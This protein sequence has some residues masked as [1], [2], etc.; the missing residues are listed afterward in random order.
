MIVSLSFTFQ[1]KVIILLLFQVVCA[2]VCCFIFCM[3][4]GSSIVPC[5][6]PW[7]LYVVISFATYEC[8]LFLL[9]SLVYVCIGHHT[10]A[11]H[12][13]LRD[14]PCTRAPVVF[15]FAS[16][17]FTPSTHAHTYTQTVSR[18]HL[19]FPLMPSIHTYIPTCL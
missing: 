13:S 7:I 1:Q 12:F 3:R 16:P 18:T 9:P 17:L 19:L 8:Y 11:E 2:C 5:L 14:Y 6:V 4:I 10:I 15:F